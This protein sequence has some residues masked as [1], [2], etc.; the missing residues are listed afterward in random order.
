MK[1]FLLTEDEE[2][3]T[4]YCEDFC[5][6]YNAITEYNNTHYNHIYCT[7]ETEMC[8]QMQKVYILNNRTQNQ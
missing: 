1:N 5:P 2:K 6:I 3:I 7:T 4:H 8:K